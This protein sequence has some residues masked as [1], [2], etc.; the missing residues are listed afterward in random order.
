MLVFPSDHLSAL[1]LLLRPSG[2]FV[3]K[4]GICQRPP[5]QWPR[6]VLAAAVC[7]PYVLTLQ[8]QGLCAYSVL[9]QQHKQTLSLGGAKGLLATSGTAAASRRAP[10]ALTDCGS[11][12]CRRAPIGSIN[13]CT[14]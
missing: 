7:F 3:M 2:M 13:A 4:T 8:A 5:L 6:E 11:R 12:A 10:V 14:E 9:D 1:L